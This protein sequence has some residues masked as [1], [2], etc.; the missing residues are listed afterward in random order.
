VTNRKAIFISFV[1]GLLA[2]LLLIV[3]MR[4]FER[5]MSGGER[6]QI[7][8]ALKP[9]KRGTLISDEL[10]STRDVPMAYVEERAIKAN[11]R[12]KIIGV[13]TSAS[14]PAQA[15]VM[16]TDLA[17]ASEER[18]LA[19]LVQPG[20]R[21]MTVRASNA[22]DRKTNALIRPGDYVDVLATMTPP[23]VENES[24]A[25]K[26]VVLLQR[27]LVLAIGLDTEPQAVSAAAAT[28]KQH[29][30]RDMALTLSLTLAESQLL[31]LASERGQLAVA[32]RNPED[33]RV[34]EGIPDMAVGQ[35]FDTTAREQIQAGRAARA[36]EVMND[37]PVKLESVVRR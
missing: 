18:D 21:A 7:V 15:I 24:E 16:W 17:I 35:I 37:G 1:L 29:Q 11:E 33:Q 12:A 3:Y 19:S 9:I 4:Q 26:S 23:T 2:V 28:S 30:Q 10:L 34:A 22:D 36:P 5:E 14:I 32:L 27:V 13:R 6:V 8:V 20:R 25:T 31:S